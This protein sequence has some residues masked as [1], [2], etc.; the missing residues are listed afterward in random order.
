V[1]VGPSLRREGSNSRT[2][3]Y[4]QCDNSVTIVYQQC[5][6]SVLLL[7][8]VCVCR[9]ISQ[10][11]GGR[12]R[13][14]L[15]TVVSRWCYDGVTMVL[16]WCYNGAERGVCA[17]RAPYCEFVCACVCVCVCVCVYLCVCVCVCI[18]VCVC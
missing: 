14:G 2:I 16:Q 9:A 8:G 18:C 10:Q 17:A 1:C 11:R 6:S 13:L 5:N 7:E 12:V 3:V 4:Q 15:H